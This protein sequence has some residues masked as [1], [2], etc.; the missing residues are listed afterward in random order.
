[1]EEKGMDKIVKKGIKVDFHIHSAKSCWTESG[2][3][4]INLKKCNVDNIDIL[5]QKLEDEKI[6][7]FAISDH[8]SFDYNLYTEIKKKLVD[9]DNIHI[10]PAV[11]FSL[12]VEDTVLHVVTIFDDTM[13][14]KLSNLNEYIFD[15]NL[16]RPKYIEK[17]TGFTVAQFSEIISKIECDVITIVHQKKSPD[18]EKPRDRDLMSLGEENYQK[19]I[20][21]NYFDAIEFKNPKNEVFTKIYHNK[22]D[23]EKCFISGSDC[24]YWEVYPNEEE[25]DTNDVAF[26][27]I[28]ALP[29]FK[30]L[31]MSVT[32]VSRLSLTN[33]FYS[34]H[35][36]LKNLKYKVNNDEFDIE[37]S[38]GINVI[39]G[40]NS[41][42]KSALL[43]ALT[44]YPKEG[45]KKVKT[46]YKAFF[47][48]LGVEISPQVE[49]FKFNAQGE[50][51]DN[52]Q[53]KN[54]NLFENLGLSVEENDVII[55]E[56]KRYCNERFSDL[57]IYLKY[58][59]NDTNINA[60]VIELRE[61]KP[62]FHI[63]YLNAE[64]E[65]LDKQLENVQIKL[66][67]INKEIDNLTKLLKSDKDAK[68]LN[69]LENVKPGFVEHINEYLERKSINTLNNDI[70]NIIY[71]Q[72]KSKKLDISK[73]SSDIDKASTQYNEDK[74]K[75]VKS[76]VSMFKH[77]Y[78]MK[79]SYQ[80]YM[81]FDDKNI[82]YIK[83]SISEYKLYKAMEISENTFEE[84]Y[85]ILIKSLFKKNTDIFSLN[86][87]T[88]H[89]SLY[90]YT[91]NNTYKEIES[92]MKEKFT[93][94]L[95]DDTSSIS[96]VEKDNKMFHSAGLNSSMYFE[97]LNVEDKIL[98]F[99][100]P[101]DDISQS[102]I[103]TDVL[104]RFKELS[105]YNQIIFVTHNPQF[106]VNLDIDNLIYI[107]N[108]ENKFNIVS[109]ALEYENTDQ[110]ISIIDLVANTVE[111]G[112]ESIQQR[113]RRYD[114]N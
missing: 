90:K 59:C 30:G 43:H 2:V 72:L 16:N 15:D 79:K 66:D 111:G 57:L 27:Y 91:G 97:L 105:I 103:K 39:I 62:N 14:K 69:F 94:K 76:V 102:V 85:D 48:N 38:P 37:L 11:E 82:I 55:N 100:Q 54:F 4:E 80:Q 36:Y 67:L 28:K 22:N 110:G 68:L 60:K 17:N 74:I 58:V 46:K 18:P 8:D 95:Q 24:H 7:L 113:W 33:T 61:F 104:K 51:R 88:L 87:K 1:M 70:Y 109:G 44:G 114:N 20:R 45:R 19:F 83:S 101:E 78:L 32:D 77:N 75:I 98:I 106:I 6:N 47:K 99:D 112:T 12:I 81:E 52:F 107:D 63:Q 71:R 26:S 23:L 13:D 65:I 35:R 31:K 5:I 84:Y 93:S 108:K 64:K 41:A 42:G 86:N 49:E 9:K 3:K 92:F 29:T 53:S 25:G 73:I 50:I 96:I 56:L 34:P 40:D 21:L 89:E 10:L